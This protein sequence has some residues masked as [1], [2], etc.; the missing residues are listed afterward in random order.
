MVM[1]LRVAD[2]PPFDGK[3]FNKHA[4][5]KMSWIVNNLGI[6]WNGMV[7]CMALT[8]SLMTLMCLSTSVICSSLADRFSLGPW[9]IASISDHSGSNLPL[10]STIS[11]RKP[12]C[13][14][15]VCVSMNALK[16]E[17]IFLLGRCC[18]PV[19]QITQLRESEM[20]FSRT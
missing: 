13:R 11:M 6:L 4:A 19:K 20:I 1:G 16:M 15:K 9:G 5:W 14:Q 18:A 2:A 3:Q 8:H 12:W 17:S 7:C 10:A